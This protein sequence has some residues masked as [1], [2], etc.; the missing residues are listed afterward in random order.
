MKHEKMKSLAAAG[1]APTSVDLV[2]IASD[3]R[4][5][6][7][8][9]AYRES[10]IKDRPRNVIGMLKELPPAEMEAMMLAQEKVDDDAL[11]LLAN[12]RAQAVKDELA[13]KSIAT[14]RKECHGN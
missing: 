3:E 4:V 1:N 7:L 5:R 10:S 14:E 8:T 11:R 13:G 2:T 6:W 12:R 9:T